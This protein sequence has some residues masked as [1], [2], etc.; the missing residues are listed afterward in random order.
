MATPQPQTDL[1]FPRRTALQPPLALGKI[2][3]GEKTLTGAEAVEKEKPAAPPEAAAAPI[4]PRP[5][6]ALPKAPETAENN[7]AEKDKPAAP[8]EKNQEKEK[9]AVPA[10]PDWGFLKKKQPG[11]SKLKIVIAAGLVA[12]SAGGYGAYRYLNEPGAT[13]DSNASNPSESEETDSIAGN[14]ESFEEPNDDADPFDRSP[15]IATAD[16]RRMTL[17]DEPRRVNPANATPIREAN[18][19]AASGLKG[20]GRHP[21]DA[22]DEIGLPEDLD[23]DAP[24]QSE[25]ALEAD[26]DADD[27]E[28]SGPSRSEG[29]RPGRTLAP[30]SR[31]LPRDEQQPSVKTRDRRPALVL[32]DSGEDSKGGDPAEA[33][34]GYTVV[35]RKSA[36]TARVGSANPPISIVD[37]RDDD[38]ED[39][40]ALDGFVAKDISSRRAA[41]RTL[42]VRPGDAAAR[43][44]ASG[45]G[46][47]GDAGSG[48]R[49]APPA[50][51]IDG[52]GSF[53]DVRRF[54]DNGDTGAARSGA[55]GALT[56]S[57]RSTPPLVAADD[58]FGST[59]A[60][61][62]NTRGGSSQSGDTYRVAP[63]DTFWKISRKQYGTAR[64][65]QALARHNQ[66]RVP[67]P[68]RLR[69]GTQIST[70]PAA[71]LEQRYPELIERSANYRGKAEADADTSALRFEKPAADDDF[72]GAD[73][74]EPRSGAPGY[75]YGKDGAPMYRIGSDDTLTGIAQRCLGRAS[76]WSEIYEQNRNVLDNPDDLKLG[77]VI[78]LPSDASRVGLVPEGNRRR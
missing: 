46:A 5:T 53:D 67:D 59:A 19:S 17:G 76:R 11:R 47:A 78:R 45:R 43:Q 25:P 49:N 62:S 36:N 42:V 55:S 21:L 74:D 63:D 77:T 28:L 39:L 58:R 37:A 70:P 35:E 8:S 29:S 1:S 61:S 51:G 30:P 38:N 7:K 4:V 20:A 6:P 32:D 75:F 27:Q 66:D 23:A 48:R 14:S 73:S 18:R 57:R 2:A 3:G 16:A 71:V 41:S 69:T 34:D 22:D 72:S 68:Q 10:V 56:G 54:D 12:L 26:L 64:Y 50:A 33:L 40:E 15:K 60:R 31:A 9:A 65:F 52:D 13:D 44:G 24:R